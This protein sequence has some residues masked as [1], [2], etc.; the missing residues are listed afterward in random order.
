MK[1]YISNN[2]IEQKFIN[3]MVLE[4]ENEIKIL[5]QSFDKLESKKL[6]N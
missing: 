6:V 3:N 2:L 5:Q 1:K 4:H